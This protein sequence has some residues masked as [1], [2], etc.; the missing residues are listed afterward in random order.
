MYTPS[1][2]VST[3]TIEVATF[4]VNEIKMMVGNAYTKFYRVTV[5][6]ATLS[7]NIMKMMVGNAYSKVCCV[8]SNG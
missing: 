3:L 1:S 2:I 8:N 6:V 5:A 7:V 4:S